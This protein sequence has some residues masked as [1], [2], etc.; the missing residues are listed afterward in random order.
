MPETKKKNRSLNKN[1][2]KH[3]LTQFFNIEKSGDR[4]AVVAFL[5]QHSET[6]LID[7][8]RIR[9]RILLKL[10]PDDSE[11]NLTHE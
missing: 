6:P 10:K 7:L 8:V 5:E 4:K 1:E 3:L 11:T 2:A 9:N